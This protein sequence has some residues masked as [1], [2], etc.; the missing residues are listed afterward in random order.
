MDLKTEENGHPKLDICRQ[1]KNF[2]IYDF[3]DLSKFLLNQCIK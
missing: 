1:A 3:Y 2:K